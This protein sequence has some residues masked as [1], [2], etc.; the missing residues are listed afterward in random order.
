MIELIHINNKNM[1]KNLLATS[2]IEAMVVM[3]VV[4]LW[5]TWAYQMFSQSVKLVDSSEFK[6][7][8]IAMAKEW[9]EAMN[10]IR[11]TNWILFRWDL[12]NC[13]NTLNYD[14]RCLNTDNTNYVIPAWVYSIYIWADYRWYL[15]EYT[16][17]WDY[18]S[19]TFRNELEVWLD[20]NG[21]Y[22][23]WLWISENIQ[24]P[25][26][27]EIIISYLDDGLSGTTAPS[28]KEQKMQVTSRVQWVDPSS[29][30]IR[31]VELT[32]ILTNWLN[33]PN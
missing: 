24:P 1:K 7:N 30:E 33:K 27:R 20:A 8:A 11:D 13:W 31:K 15:R 28:A 12:K 32:N 19:S 4:V 25:F 29:T 17:W 10:N 2:V 26:T 5:V 23:Q 14:T 16:S 6:L 22:T 21:F 3:L 18:S 9:I